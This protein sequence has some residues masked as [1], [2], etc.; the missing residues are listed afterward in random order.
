MRR[1]DASGN[2]KS[3]TASAVLMGNKRL[4]DGGKVLG[5]DAASVVGDSNSNHIVYTVGVQ[6]DRWTNGICTCFHGFPG[7]S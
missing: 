7:I 6:P 4:K 1:D 2:C 3:E 5:I